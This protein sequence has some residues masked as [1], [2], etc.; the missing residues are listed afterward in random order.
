MRQRGVAVAERTAPV[1]AGWRSLVAVHLGP[2]RRLAAAAAVA[3]V[4]PRPEAVAVAAVP[5][6]VPCRCSN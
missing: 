5:E 3:A 6:P 4:F 1:A 2:V